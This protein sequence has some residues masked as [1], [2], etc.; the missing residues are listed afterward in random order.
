[1]AAT[2]V[3][4]D[5]RRCLQTGALSTNVIWR[6]E[7]RRTHERSCCPPKQ[8]RHCNESPNKVIHFPPI[9]KLWIHGDRESDFHGT[10]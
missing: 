2:F 9:Q 10:E 8:Q 7:C 4:Y 3:L 6:T 5:Q 1:M